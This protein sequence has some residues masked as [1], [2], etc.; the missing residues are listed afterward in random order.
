MIDRAFDKSMIVSIDLS[1]LTHGLTV[2]SW[3]FIAK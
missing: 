3:E 2:N 1:T